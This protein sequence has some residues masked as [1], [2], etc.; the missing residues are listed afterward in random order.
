MF[1]TS[2]LKCDIVW[3]YCS[4]RNGSVYSWSSL[5]FIGLVIGL[6]GLI[7]VP[8]VSLL[9]CLVLTYRYSMTTL[10]LTLGNDPICNPTLLGLAGRV[11]EITICVGM[12]RFFS[13]VGLGAERP[14]WIT[15]VC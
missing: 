9:D 13:V 2:V 14:P 10:V 4:C 1:R 15:N 8:V 5:A 6:V 12:F 11:Y 3:N 7:L